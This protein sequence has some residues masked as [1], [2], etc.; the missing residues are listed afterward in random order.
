M[1]HMKESWLHQISWPKYV[2]PTQAQP[3]ETVVRDR[4]VFDCRQKE[5]VERMD[6]GVRG[7]T[8]VMNGLSGLG[9]GASPFYS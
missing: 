8:R 9:D 4:C 1:V 6:H 2:L 3:Q 5:V 7:E